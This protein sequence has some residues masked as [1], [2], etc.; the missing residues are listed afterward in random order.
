MPANKARIIVDT[1]L[2]IS[3]FL[4]GGQSKLRF[5]L[6]NKNL[7]LLWSEELFEELIRV[8]QREKFRSFISI[9]HLSG[10]LEY[11]ISRSEIVSVNSEVKICRDPSDNFLLSLA[12]DGKADYLVTGDKDLL[13]LKQLSITKILSLSAFLDLFLQNGKTER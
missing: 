10:I 6:E 11:L 3:H 2:W 13:E 12:L 8:S 1:N 7:T 9:P 4:S 5:I